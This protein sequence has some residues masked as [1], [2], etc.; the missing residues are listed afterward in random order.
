MISIAL[1]SG[2]NPP[3]RDFGW[4]EGCGGGREVAAIMS[5]LS[6]PPTLATRAHKGRGEVCT[7]AASALSPWFVTPYI[8]R[9]GLPA[10]AI[11]GRRN[12]PFGPGGSTRRLHHYTGAK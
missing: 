1:L 12:K 3:I 7:T 6:R 11:N 9:A 2:R 8:R 10:M 5:R 4:E